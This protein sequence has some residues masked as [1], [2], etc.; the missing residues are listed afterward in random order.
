M[1]PL[2]LPP[3]T[4]FLSL[5]DYSFPPIPFSLNPFS[6]HLCVPLFP[7]SLFSLLFALYFC[8]VTPSAS[9]YPSLSSYIPPSFQSLPLLLISFLIPY[10]FSFPDSSSF[11]PGSLHNLSVLSPSPFLLSHRFSIPLLP[12]LSLP[13]LFFPLDLSPVSLPHVP[14]WPYFLYPASYLPVSFSL[15]V[16]PSSASPPFPIFS[17]YPIFPLSRCN[18]HLGFV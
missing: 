11:L 1:L 5:P 12:V 7:V 4:S 15:F 8:P 3:P 9:F 13:P 6:H 2:S 18:T 16:F 14:L 10:S 17:P